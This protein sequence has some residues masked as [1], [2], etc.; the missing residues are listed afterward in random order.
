MTAE[1]AFFCF[2]AGVASLQESP[3]HGFME[4]ACLKLMKT[5]NEMQETHPYSFSNK[6]VLPP[7]LQFCFRQVAEEKWEHDCFEQFVIQCM[8]FIQSVVQCTA[9]WPTKS[10]RV[11]GALGPSIEETKCALAKQA[12]ETVRTLLNNEHL[13]V[14]CDVLVKR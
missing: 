6:A 13:V 3:F 12:E 1:L 8:T 4:K 9:Y 10:G 2:S 11:V 5:L 14:L 7:V